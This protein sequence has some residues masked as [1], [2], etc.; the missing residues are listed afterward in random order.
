MHSNEN[1]DEEQ[2]LRSL[3]D[4]GNRID[5]KE[6]Q[7]ELQ[8]TLASSKT[9]PDA[10]PDIRIRLF[11]N[12]DFRTLQTILGSKDLSPTLLESYAFSANHPEA[13]RRAI[14][15]SPSVTANIIWAYYRPGVNEN[16]IVTLS[17][18]PDSLFLVIVKT[19]EERSRITKQITKPD[20]CLLVKIIHNPA[21]RGEILQR[22]TDLISAYTNNN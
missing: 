20:V 12:L 21:V 8:E 22:I 13:I 14:L 16:D 9:T 4:T 1:P 2:L 7:R 19:I 17:K 6:R 5:R 11:S 3:I 15:F 18:T 10:L